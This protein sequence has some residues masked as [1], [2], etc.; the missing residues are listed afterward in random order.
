MTV[1]GV[2][3]GEDELEVFV[4]G[5]LCILGLYA[6]ITSLPSQQR[7]RFTSSTLH[8]DGKKISFEHT[9]DL[10][11]FMTSAKE[12]GYLSYVY[13]TIAVILLQHPILQTSSSIPGIAIDNYRTTLPMKKGLSSSAAI[14]V[15]IAKSFNRYYQLGLTKAQIMEIAYQ[16]EMMTPSHCGRM[17][18]CV[19]MGAG[20]IGLMEFINEECQL[21]ILINPSPLYFVV[22]DLLSEKDTVIILRELNA[23]FPFPQNTQ[24]ELMHQYVHAIAK[25]AMEGKAGIENGEVQ[26]LASAMRKAQEAFDA[27]A[28]PNCPSQLTAPRLHM[29]MEDS[30]LKEH[31][32]VVK[33]VGSQGDGS[34]QILCAN[35]REQHEVLRYIKEVHRM[36]GFPLTIPVRHEVIG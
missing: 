15:L 9:F 34:A 18:Q 11:Y 4:P 28:L 25:I 1:E 23:C 29:L 17:D 31:A 8:D 36:E 12:G 14:C 10:S 32:L 5:R 7:I 6:R 27:G 2:E 3:R 20:A 13:G 30:Y 21:T 24:Q 33:G 22:V 26:V 35:E 19:V 16:G